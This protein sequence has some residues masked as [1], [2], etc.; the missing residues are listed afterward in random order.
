MLRPVREDDEWGVLKLGAVSFG[1]FD[2]NENKALPPAAQAATISRGEVWSD[3]HQPCQ[4][5][6]ARRSHG[7]YHKETRDKLMLCDKIFRVVPLDPAPIDSEFLT[8][9]LR[10]Q[11]CAV[12]SKRSVTGT[13][14][15]MKKHL[16]ARPAGLT[17]PLPP[18]IEEQRKIVRD[19]RDAWTKARGLRA[20]A[21]ALVHRLG[22]SS[23]LRST[24]LKTL[25]LRCKCRNAYW[26]AGGENPPDP[27]APYPD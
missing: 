25:S 26:V 8:E 15:T 21:T 5:Y 9:V 13:S 27:T 20:D 24:P 3:P 7:F 12:R 2:Q 14:P 4:H 22:S 18:E 11:M 23:R 1:T 10:I 17:F 6:S 16:Q 19:L